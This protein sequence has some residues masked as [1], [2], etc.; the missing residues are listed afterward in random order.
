MTVRRKKWKKWKRRW[1]YDMFY[2]KT[3]NSRNLRGV[4]GYWYM[5]HTSLKPWP[6][7]P[8]YLWIAPNGTDHTHSHTDKNCLPSCLSLICVPCD[9]SLAGICGTRVIFYIYPLRLL[10]SRLI[11]ILRDD[12]HSP[13]HPLSCSLRELFLAVAPVTGGGWM[14]MTKIIILF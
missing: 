12:I 10:L 14:H 9:H 7:V 8:F 1:C 11:I 13:W 5:K 2:S 3:T 4:G 6:S